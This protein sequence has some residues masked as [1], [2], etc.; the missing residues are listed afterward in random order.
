MTDIAVIPY[1]FPIVADVLA[2]VTAEA[3]GR[4]EMADVVRMRLPISFHLRKEVQLVDLFQFAY[5]SID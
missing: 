5:R 1:S 3:A 4:S 2:I